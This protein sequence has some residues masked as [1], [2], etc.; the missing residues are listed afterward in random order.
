MRA[1]GA[2]VAC[3]ALARVTITGKLALARAA[4]FG[5][6][7][8]LALRGA[9]WRPGPARDGQP[10]VA[11]VNVFELEAADRLR[12][13]GVDGSQC[14]D[15]PVHGITGGVHGL[16]GAAMLLRLRSGRCGE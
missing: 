15:K 10:P 9:A 6:R 4:A 13:G 8:P 1:A 5:V 14:E 11:E 7:V 16:R 2:A 3:R 12:A